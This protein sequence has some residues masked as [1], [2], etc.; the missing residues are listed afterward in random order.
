MGKIHRLMRRN[1][2]KQKPNETFTVKV[3]G[4]LVPVCPGPS[5]KGLDGE[6]FA[7][8]KT[9]YGFVYDM[10][11][12]VQVPNDVQDEETAVRRYLAYLSVLV[13]I[14]LDEMALSAMHCND[15]A[16]LMKQRMLVEYAAK[17]QYFHD[18][19]DYA[20]FSTTIDAA[21]SI[22]M[23]LEYD[24]SVLAEVLDNRKRDVN[25]KKN[26][27][28]RV[29]HLKHLTLARIMKSLGAKADYPW[30]YGAPSALMHGDSE[31]MEV[32][33]PV[34]EHG[35]M[36]VVISLPDEQLNA[37]MVDAGGNTVMF[38]EA[39]IARFRSADDLLKGRLEAIS[40]WFK[41]L[42]L[43][44]PHG[45]DQKVLDSFRAE[46]E[47]KGRAVVSEPASAAGAQL[48]RAMI[49]TSMSRPV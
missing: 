39:F 46:L 2:N 12:D 30:I 26:R 21:A 23:K 32:V 19:P 9:L 18:H 35:S 13:Q 28:A 11:H 5:R 7:A 20:L 22:V 48:Q 42:V 36:K 14:G 37:M 38:C 8:L 25:E 41:R 49:P 6:I 4:G 3:A 10:R 34:D 31:G 40:D 47:S 29:A 27:F 24:A 43:K 33:L 17:G 15:V 1:A 45:R 44:H 16:V